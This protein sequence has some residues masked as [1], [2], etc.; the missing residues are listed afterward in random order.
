VFFGCES[1]KRRVPQMKSISPLRF[2]GGKTRAC[3]TFLKYLPKD[4]TTICSPF[5][6]G[7]SFEL[8]CLMNYYIR[9]FAYDLFE[10]LVLFWKCLLED[11][12]RLAEIVARYLPV[13]TKE[14]FYH[15][16]R[17][18]RQIN[19]PW[20][21]AAAT[22]VL[23]R[24]SFSGTME[25][26]GFSP[27]EKNGRNGRFNENNVEFLRNFRVPDGMLSVE[28]LSFEE[29]ILRH[30][31]SFIYGDPPYLVD[32]KLY[33]RRGD[34]HD[35]DHILLLELLGSRDNWMLS[36]NDCAEVRKL[37]RG[38]H[39]VDDRDGLSWQ[40]GMSKSKKSKE[41]LILSK[42][43]PERLGLKVSRPV[44]IGSRKS[45]QQRIPLIG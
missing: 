39:I 6:G 11:P 40:Y 3:R 19:D 30:P 8:Y 15:L 21:R 34:L 1:E 31:E 43:L 27:L 37:Y 7:G 14:K 33:G 35:I 26:G 12:R 2:A 25:S 38:F 9:I 24:T 5:L 29:S 32:S 23:N 22:Y 13:V 17:T 18:Y 10:A 16:Q 44:S 45:I 4:V 42:D 20:E 36:Y 28:R 41:L